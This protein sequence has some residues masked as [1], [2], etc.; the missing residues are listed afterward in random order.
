[1]GNDYESSE[2]RKNNFLIMLIIYMLSIYLLSFP[3]SLYNIYEK[4]M[5]LGFSSIF[6]GMTLSLWANPLNKELCPVS[7]LV[8]WLLI[9]GLCIG[10]IYDYF[11]NGIIDIGMISLRG[12]V[13]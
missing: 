4:S 7:A 1:M 2:F 6:L 10:T 11:A 8:V 3:K 12:S 9:T 5:F 13:S